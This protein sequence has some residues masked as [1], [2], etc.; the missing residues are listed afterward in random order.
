MIH[1]DTRRGTNEI[2]SFVF[3][4]L[5]R[6][7]TGAQEGVAWFC[8][9]PAIEIAHDTRPP[10][11]D[12]ATSLL[13]LYFVQKRRAT[14]WGDEDVYCL[15]N[16]PGRAG[17]DRRDRP[18]DRQ[19]AK[20]G[21]SVQRHRRFR[22]PGGAAPIRIRA[23]GRVGARWAIQ[24]RRYSADEHCT[25]VPALLSRGSGSGLGYRRLV[26]RRRTNDKGQKLL[27]VVV[28]PS[29][30]VLRQKKESYIQYLRQNEVEE[31]RLLS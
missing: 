23:T 17:Q 4:F 20:R 26:E 6:F 25:G 10:R 3:L 2:G 13:V 29:S 1:G 24:N 30:F 15:C 28:R 11:S 22:H 16:D 27:P 19:H 14:S 9:G 8:S 12:C 18:V 21:R 5:R 7:Y 31:N